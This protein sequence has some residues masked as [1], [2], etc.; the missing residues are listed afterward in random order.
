MWTYRGNA[1]LNAN[2][3]KKENQINFIYFVDFIEKKKKKTM[4]KICACVIAFRMGG[5]GIQQ[6]NF[7]YITFM[8]EE[9]PCHKT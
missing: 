1:S 4:I 6:K 3:K 2:W 9:H 8:Y 5:G 7:Q